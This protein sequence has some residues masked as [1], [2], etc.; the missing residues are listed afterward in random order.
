MID[1]NYERYRTR[2]RLLDYDSSIVPPH[3]VSAGLPIIY[4]WEN[5]NLTILSNQLYTIAQNNGFDGT[6]AQFLDFFAHGGGGIV[7][8]TIA[9]FPVTGKD[10]TLYLDSETDIVYYFKATTTEISPAVAEENKIVIAGT[11]IDEIT[12]I[13]TYFLYIPIRAM[14][15]EDTIL[16]S[17]D[18]AEY[19]G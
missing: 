5:T 11:E 8:G 6:L 9:T 18:A 17:G 19:I 16:N 10:S 1:W 2:D 4:P 15:I 3:P 13:T 14:L 12:H 7:V